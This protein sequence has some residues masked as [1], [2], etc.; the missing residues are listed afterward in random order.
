MLKYNF[1]N[2]LVK[3]IIFQK[4][5]SIIL[6]EVKVNFQNRLSNLKKK[7]LDISTFEEMETVF[8]QLSYINIYHF[9]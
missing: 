2:L 3:L 4:Q 6:E 9:F 1:N 5:L 8:I 7:L